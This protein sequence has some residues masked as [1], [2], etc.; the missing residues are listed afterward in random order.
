M[1]KNIL[2]FPC[3]SEIAL[4]IY[5][6]LEFSAHFN[7]IGASS[8]DD[9]GKF[10]YKNY[11]DNV[12]FITSPDFIDDIKR[13]VREYKIDA[14]YPAMDEVIT[15]LKANESEI[16]CP[17]V[18]SSLETV[19]ICMNKEKTYAKLGDYIRVPKVYNIHDVDTY[20]VFC[21][22]KVG[23]GSRGVRKIN[24]SEELVRHMSD[25]ADSLVCQYLSGDE[26][27]VDCFTDR[28]GNLLFSAPRRRK[29]IMNGISVNTVP[30]IDNGNEFREIIDTIN[31]VISFRGAWFAQFK[32][33]DEGNLVLLEIASR[34]GGSS[35][36]FRGKG[37]N[38]AQL[39]LFDLFGVNVSVIKNDYEIEMD[40]ALDNIFKMEMEYDQVYVDFDDC[41]ILDKSNVNPYLVAFIFQCRNNGV[42][43]T[44][45]TK[46]AHDLA[47]TLKSF[48]LENLFDEI[49]HIRQID[50]KAS[51]IDNMNSIFIDDSF[52]ERKN[53]SEKL[54]I[55]VFGVDMIKSLLNS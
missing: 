46:H 43:V 55:P 45:L 14:V 19:Q 7:L 17:V 53:V 38:F 15:I 39:A 10:V 31:G 3:G 47:E 13:I 33:D 6:S 28:K 52:A 34:F 11:V 30:V 32:R 41:L 37:V 22:P 25:N 26:Y 1:K 9:H 29:R 4:E 2:V 5:R 21:K 49:I 20:P 48:R 40:R 24:D 23:Y 44:L 51:Y 35:S 54:G 42:K 36:L 18:S 50:S 16:G 12:P 27:T 8:V